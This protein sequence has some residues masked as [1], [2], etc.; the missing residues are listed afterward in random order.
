MSKTYHSNPIVLLYNAYRY[1]RLFKRAETFTQEELYAYQYD[2]LKTIIAYA[3]A[4]VPYYRKAFHDCGF[5]LGD[6]KCIND[7]KGLPYLTKDILRSCPPEEF[8]SDESSRLGVV[9]VKTS[10]ST[11]VPLNFACD[12]KARAAKFAITFR[13]FQEAGY[14]LG[15][16]QFYLKNCFYQN[17]AFKY[18]RL[19]NRTQMH[20]Y[21]NSKSNARAC[22]LLLRKH[23]PVHILAHPNALLEFGSSLEDVRF[24]FRK[25]KGI[26]T[27]SEPLTPALRRQ[28]EDC[29]NAKVFDYY[30]NKESSLIAYETR[31]NGFLLGEHFSYAE[32]LPQEDLDSDAMHGEIVST[33]FFS[34]AMPLIRYKNADIV[35]LRCNTHGGAYR[36]VEEVS[37]RTSE[38]ICLPDGNK[39]RIFNFMHSQLN[40]V[41]MYQIVQESLGK[42]FIDVVPIDAS[43]AVDATSIVN[44]L[45]SYIG[46]ETMQ[47]ELRKVSSLQMTEAGKTPRIISKV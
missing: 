33:T 16:P 17:Q 27:M 4:H 20:A 8:L 40:N 31:Q 47:F 41:R 37:G 34:Y 18:S 46:S 3:M 45:R 6:F 28:I 21:M 43:Q 35:R 12:V 29:F 9:Y 22:E 24:T 5:E 10:G 30:S 7:I 42:I 44:E 13:A 32:I 11:G 1:Y 2:K 14:S 19:V 36:E 25:L 23:P 26:S 39:V 15:A 38:A